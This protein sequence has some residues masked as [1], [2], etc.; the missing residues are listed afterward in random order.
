M[1]QN[2][3]KGEEEVR[4]MMQNMIKGVEGKMIQNMIKVRRRRR[5]K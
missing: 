1:M 4:K 3:I 2:R 5:G